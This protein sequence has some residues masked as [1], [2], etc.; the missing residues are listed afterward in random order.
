MPIESKH[1]FV[2]YYQVLQVW[3][4]ASLDAIKKA[5]FK[6][7]KLHHPDVAD[8]TPD[9]AKRGAV[10][11]TLINEAFAVLSDPSKRLQFDEELRRRGAKSVAPEKKKADKRSAQLAYEQAKTAMRHNRYD[12]AVVLLKSATNYDPNNP[13]YLSWYGFAL[14][15][16]NAKL[17]EARDACKKALEMEFYNA[18]YHANLGYVYHQAGLT[19]TARE[20]FEEA[21]KWDAENAL[22]LKHLYGSMQK[23]R[24]ILE[25]IL[26]FLGLSLPRSAGG[27]AGKRAT[28]VRS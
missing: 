21:L 7:A 1:Q 3:P 25:S 13:E 19:S 6:L 26:S 16:L 11:F 15:A 27:S 8:K 12:K 22:A 23:R 24:S 9:P 10:D 17:H 2:D 14:A 20:C 18:E 5:Y 4:T 28:K